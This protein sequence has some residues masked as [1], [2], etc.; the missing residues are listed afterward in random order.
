MRSK[1]S[2]MLDL[3]EQVPGLSATIFSGET[4]GALERAI[5]GEPIGTLITR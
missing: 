1:V 3:V 5:L 2:Q 4:P